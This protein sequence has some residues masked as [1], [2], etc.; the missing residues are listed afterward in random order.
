L[1]GIIFFEKRDKIFP[2]GFVIPKNNLFLH[3]QNKQ[4][5]DKKNFSTISKKKKEQTRLP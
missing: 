5:D 3:S 4:D 2:K 1:P